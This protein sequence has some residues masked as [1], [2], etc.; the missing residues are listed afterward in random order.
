MYWTNPG[1]GYSNP[2]WDVWQLHIYSIRTQTK[3][4]YPTLCEQL[5]HLFY[6]I[7][8]R[9]LLYSLC[10]IYFLWFAEVLQQ[11]NNCIRVSIVKLGWWLSM[12]FLFITGAHSFKST[13]HNIGAVLFYGDI[14]H[15]T[16]IYKTFFCCIC[17]ELALL[18]LTRGR[19]YC[20]QGSVNISIYSSFHACYWSSYHF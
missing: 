15:S 7:M 2:E 6:S 5:L 13:V 11:K 8:N 17:L 10:F 19:N 9:I 18:W 16:V 1:L 14:T 12:T 4:S 20:R 3:A